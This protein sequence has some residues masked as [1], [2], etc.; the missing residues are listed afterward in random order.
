MIKKENISITIVE[1]SSNTIDDFS[2][3]LAE[4]KKENYPQ[5]VVL[6]IKKQIEFSSTDLAMFIELLTQNDNVV[7]GIQSTNQELINYANIS[8]IAVFPITL[9]NEETTSKNIEEKKEVITTNVDKTIQQDKPLNNEKENVDKTIKQ[10]KPLNNEKES[11]VKPNLT[12]VTQKE[13]SSS[14]PQIVVESFKNKEKPL[15]IDNLVTKNE[16]IYSKEKDLIVGNKVESGAELISDANIFI[17]D[18]MQGSVFAG[19]KGNKKVVIFIHNFEA[20][21]VVIAGVYKKFETIPENLKN[22]SVNITLSDDKL[23]FKIN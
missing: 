2:K 6:N 7:I 20:S 18:L 4:V 12:E 5:A 19:V 13:T 3:Q 1:V 21:L 9:N 15:V 16:Q 10:D 23:H 14:T 11:V 17:Y 8:G 22:K